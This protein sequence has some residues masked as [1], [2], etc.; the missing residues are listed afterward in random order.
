V[1]RLVSLL[2][3]RVQEKVL[4][5]GVVGDVH[6]SHAS[7][8]RTTR[9]PT[10]NGLSTRPQEYLIRQTQVP[11]IPFVS[12]GSSSPLRSAAYAMALGRP[13]GF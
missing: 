6:G 9:V 5:E 4:T 11:Y 7:K 1:T 8:P 12:Y 3:F 2:E 13:W 10:H